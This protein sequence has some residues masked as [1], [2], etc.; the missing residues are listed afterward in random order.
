M[1]LKYIIEKKKRRDHDQI[2]RKVLKKNKR[3]NTTFIEIIIV[4]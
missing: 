2:E 1:Q 3:K 4:E